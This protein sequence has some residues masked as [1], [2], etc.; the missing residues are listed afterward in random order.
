VLW[1]AGVTSFALLLLLVVL[2]AALVYG[3]RRTLGR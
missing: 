2:T 3:L 1:V